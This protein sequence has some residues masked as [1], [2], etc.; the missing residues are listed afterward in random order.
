MTNDEINRAV[1]ERVMGWTR[2][3]GLPRAW[4]RADGSWAGWWYEEPLMDIDDDV[5]YADSGYRIIPGRWLDAGSQ[6]WDTA[7]PAAWGALLVWLAT[8]R[9]PRGTSLD[10]WPDE[11]LWEVTIGAMLDEQIVRCRDAL[12][13]RALCL[14]A[15]RAYGVEGV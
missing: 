1:A 14:A 4:K 11:Q 12:P 15:L 9:E 2:H 8:D 13:G 3:D 5:E 10:Y 6:V 7:D